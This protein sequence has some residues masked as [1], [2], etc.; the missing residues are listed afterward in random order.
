[1]SKV[2]IITG[3]PTSKVSKADAEAKL[4]AHPQFPKNADFTLEEVEGRWIAAI[5]AKTA[6]GNPF[7]DNAAPEGGGGPPAAEG[8]P[9][10]DGPPEGDDGAGSDHADG[11]D[12]P[13][14][15]EKGDKE[16]G[17]EKSEI[18]HLTQL[19]T[20]LVQAL[21]LDPNGASPVPGVDDPHGGP[22]GL[23]SEEGGPSEGPPEPGSDNKTHTVHERALKPGEAPPGSTPVGAPAFASVADDHPWKG[24][25]GQKRTF[26][27]EEEIGDQPLSSV[28]AELSQLANGT[29]YRVAQLTEGQQD[30]RR[31][32]RALISR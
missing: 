21:G 26:K 17:G 15:K 24:V 19:V 7:A 11:E 28:H 5:A 23:P 14:G 16:K 25:L 32:A 18:A 27:V 31:V 8:P 29:G 3:P 9:S 20:L 30:G 4:I 1:M 2:Q 12:K 22:D 6:D 10:P 13:E